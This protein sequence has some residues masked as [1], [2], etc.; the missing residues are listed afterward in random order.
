MNKFFHSRVTLGSFAWIQRESIY[1]LHTGFFVYFILFYFF[2]VHKL[3]FSLSMKHYFTDLET[4][5]EVYKM[6]F[7]ITNQS[8][9]ILYID[10]VIFFYSP[11]V[12]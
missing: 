5:L 7:Y 2:K 12:L 1:Q 11:I 10:V 4:S 3:G 9:Y 8:C 6:W